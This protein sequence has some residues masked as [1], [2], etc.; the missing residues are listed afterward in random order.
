MTKRFLD[1]LLSS[2]G[3]LCASPVLVP[4]LFLTWLQD[5]HS[6]FYIAPR[7]GKDGDMFRMVKIRSMTV[8]ADRTGVDSTSADDKRITR[9]GHFVRRFKLD[10]LAQLWNV[11]IGDMSLVGP[12]PNVQR[13]VSLYTDVE[14]KILEV[15][16]GITDMASIVFSDEGEILKGKPD[17]DLSYNQLIRPWKSRLC[18]LYIEH[19]SLGL[20]L[21]LV[22]LTAVAIVSRAKALRGIQN[23]L[24]KLHADETLKK[25]AAREE[26]LRPS[27]PPGSLEIVLSR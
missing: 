2:A 24:E 27:P 22:F 1:I 26:E 15:R 25:A 4:I 18:L 13:D 19:Q 8:N 3:L 14:K 10:E 7:V 6:P 17:P 5:R 11:L 21:K 23:I 16:P 12:R 9:V 20:D